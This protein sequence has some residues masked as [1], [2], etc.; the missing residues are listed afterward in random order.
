M[1]DSDNLYVI[2]LFVTC[3]VTCGANPLTAFR[4]GTTFGSAKSLTYLNWQALI[5]GYVS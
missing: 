1:F 5:R 2:T 3:F 4:D